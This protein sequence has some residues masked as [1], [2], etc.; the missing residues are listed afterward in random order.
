MSWAFA[1]LLLVI[2]AWTL[3]PNGLAAICWTAGHAIGH[4]LARR[5]FA[6]PTGEFEDSE[7]TSV[8]DDSR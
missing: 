7:N 2:M 5:A 6:N 3:W 1:S 8:P 4:R